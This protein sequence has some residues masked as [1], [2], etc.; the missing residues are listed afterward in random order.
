MLLLFCCCCCQ[1]HRDR[2]TSRDRRVVNL[3]TQ[4]SVEEFKEGPFSQ[5]EVKT[6]LEKM[7]TVKAEAEEVHSEKIVRVY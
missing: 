2:I 3:A 7:A 4:Q 1:Y 6:F 5:S